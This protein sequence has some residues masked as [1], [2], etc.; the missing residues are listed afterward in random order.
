VKTLCWALVC[1][2]AA[3]RPSAA[4][5]K[6][7]GK[8][9]VPL[10]TNEDLDRVSA[11][12]G[13]TGVL[14][15]PFSEPALAAPAAGGKPGTEAYWRKEA[16]RV[17]ER[18]R[19]LSERA[20]PLRHELAEARSNSSAKPRRGINPPPLAAREARLRAIEKRMTELVTELEERARREGALP[21]WLR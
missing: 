4:E 5:E 11:L 14:S 17:R 9:P 6:A 21:G 12:R 18:V 19:A 2:L 7:D 16:A 20:E 13:Q 8:K 3:L 1:S 10:Y 15:E